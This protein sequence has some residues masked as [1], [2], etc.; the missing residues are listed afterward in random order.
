MTE[1]LYVHQPNG[2]LKKSTLNPCGTT[3]LTRLRFFSIVLHS[4][5]R[6]RG[7]MD[8][9][10][11][12]RRLCCVVLCRQYRPRASIHDATP[13]FTP[14]GPT[15]HSQN[16]LGRVSRVK[17]TGFLYQIIGLCAHLYGICLLTS[18][19][20]NKTHIFCGKQQPQAPI[21]VRQGCRQILHHSFEFL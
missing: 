8:R 2:K 3:V 12:G 9:L 19:S 7:Q 10:A 4:A 6:Y 14:F 20:T 15:I 11:L 13:C 21:T 17:T 1:R 18:L 16:H 5:A